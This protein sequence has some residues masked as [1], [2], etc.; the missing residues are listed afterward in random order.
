MPR[1]MTLHIEVTAVNIEHVFDEVEFNSLRGKQDEIIK[2]EI[3]LAP[4][5][6]H[7]LLIRTNEQ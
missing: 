7:Q 1:C 5:E 6:P 2:L 3:P 4:A